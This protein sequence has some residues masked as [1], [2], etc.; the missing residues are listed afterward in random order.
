M[1][2]LSRILGSLIILGGI[3]LFI[4]QS[5]LFNLDSERII[6]IV[7]ALTSLILFYKYFGSGRKIFIII[8][9]VVF[10]YSI[11]LF[12]KSNY[13]MELSTNLLIS[14][15]LL[16]ISVATF[17]FYFENVKNFGLV[18][19]TLFFFLS[20]VYYLIDSVGIFKSTS[21]LIFNFGFDYSTFWSLILILCG[22]L[23]VLNS[24]KPKLHV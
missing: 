15:A 24:K 2:K 18:I 6:S 17:F 9:I 1:I 12:V 10:F 16:S 4:S 22:I 13:G 8:T 3:G 14:S 20:G 11:L 5:N 7:L 19:I 21:L 23:I